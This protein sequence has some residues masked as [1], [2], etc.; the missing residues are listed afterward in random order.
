MGTVLDVD[1]GQNRRQ[2]GA[3]SLFPWV[4]LSGSSRLEG[5]TYTKLQISISSNQARK[6]ECLMDSH[7]G[8]YFNYMD[9]KVVFEDRLF[10]LKCEWEKVCSGQREQDFHSPWGLWEGGWLL[11][12]LRGDGRIM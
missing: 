8:V 2:D 9:K 1:T 10:K 4:H 6:R 3:P 11:E 12:I 7:K 5:L